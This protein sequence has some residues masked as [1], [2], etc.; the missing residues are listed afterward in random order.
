[1]NTMHGYT[2]RSFLT[3]FFMTLLVLTFVMCTIVI[4]QIIELLAH[5]I[6]WR[7]V[8]RVFLCGIPAALGYA[9]PISSLVAVLLIFGR[10][11]ADGEITAMKACGVSMRQL[12]SPVLLLAVVL[13]IICWYI[14]MGL[15]PRSHYARKS[16]VAQ[17]GAESPIKLIDAGQVI[18]DFDGYKVRVGKKR[19]DKIYDIV[20]NDFTGSEPVEIRASS[21]VMRTSDD[22][23]ELILEL[24]DVRMVPGPGNADEFFSEYWPVRIPVAKKRVY[25]KRNADR[26]L[27]ELQERLKGLP[28]EYTEMGQMDLAKAQ[29][30][31]RVEMNKRIVLSLSCFTFVLLG[32]PLGIKA[33]RKE[34]S[35]GLAI[36][37]CVVVGFYLF[38]IIADS[39]A[40]KP[41]YRPDL[42]IWIP[43]IGG[44]IAGTA[45]LWRAR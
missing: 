36:S 44:V 34:S 12:V 24:T 3:A 18:D 13:T 15:A 14:H 16:I 17:I 39:L 22:G 21:G 20:I 7:I 23:D 31:L 5:D 6:S 30:S 35:T 27:L 26:T 4:F 1:M 41:G 19:R 11:S 10:L 42:I 28:V 9:I 2:S 43:V 25:C 37:L 33:H 45:M 40:R 29:M 38:I 32:I 8:L